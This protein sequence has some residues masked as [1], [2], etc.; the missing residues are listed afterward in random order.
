[1]GAITTVDRHA[2]VSPE[3][4]IEECGFRMLQPHEIGRGMAFDDGYVVMGNNREKVRQYGNAVT[5]P[6]MELLLQRCLETLQ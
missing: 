1:M 3:Q 2:L 6:A 4:L 5:P